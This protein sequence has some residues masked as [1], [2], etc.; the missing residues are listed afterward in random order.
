MSHV[1]LLLAAMLVQEPAAAAPPAPPLVAVAGAARYRLSA[2][3]DL[4]LEYLDEESR[5]AF[6]RGL[7]ID[8]ERPLGLLWSQLMAGAM[9][10]RRESGDSA[11]T[12][13]FNPALDVGILARW[14][15]GPAGWH[16]TL[17]APVL[18][19]RLRGEAVTDVVTPRWATSA[20]DLAEALE[21]AGEATFASA[22]RASW[23]ALFTPNENDV[24]AAVGRLLIARGAVRTIENAVG[25]G[26]SVA[27]LRRALAGADEATALPPPV[28]ASLAGFGATVR[29]TLRPVTALRYG[30]GWILVLQSPDAPAASWLVH[31]TDPAPGG[32]AEARAFAVALLGRG[33]GSRP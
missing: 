15:R 7:R 10:V 25:Y 14:A 3:S 29:R 12:L 21:A 8:R 22:E 4:L 18:G 1:A 28:A 6:A 13:W 11:E 20:A 17:V 27:T 26:L 23:T 2:S 33:A 9:Q 30:E 32:A 24:I 16:A 5:A 19:E 31:F